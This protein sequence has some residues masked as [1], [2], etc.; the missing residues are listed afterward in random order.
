[1]MCPS[2]LTPQGSNEGQQRKGDSTAYNT[3]NAP[4]VRTI[5]SVSVCGS[6]IM[7]ALLKPNRV[8]KARRAE[9]APILLAINKD[10]TAAHVLHACLHKS[11]VWKEIDQDG[12]VS[13]N[14]SNDVFYGRHSIKEAAPS[15]HSHSRSRRRF[16][17]GKI[18]T[19]SKGGEMNNAMRIETPHAPCSN[20][21]QQ[22][23]GQEENADA[24][25]TLQGT[26]M[27]CMDT[28]S[29]I[30]FWAARVGMCFGWLC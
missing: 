21:Q 30:R 3:P 20:Q 19:A 11:Q 7:L 23:E 12:Q 26:S 18:S 22:Q 15:V 17:Q 6:I 2:G 16:L 29:R 25:Y 5:S 13:V 10:I 24:K 28:S 1:M 8:G 9:T 27:F 4:H 14:A